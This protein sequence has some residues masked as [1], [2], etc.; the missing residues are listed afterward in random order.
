MLSSSRLSQQTNQSVHKLHILEKTKLLLTRKMKGERI[1]GAKYRELREAAETIDQEIHSLVTQSYKDKMKEIDDWIAVEDQRERQEQVDA[2]PSMASS[3][4]EL[5]ED[6]DIASLIEIQDASK[7]QI[8]QPKPTK[9]QRAEV[10][11]I[12]V[13]ADQEATPTATF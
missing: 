3:K 10:A 13:K 8:E 4:I 1:G 11:E 9:S 2:S 7:M 5:P 12:Q 6:L